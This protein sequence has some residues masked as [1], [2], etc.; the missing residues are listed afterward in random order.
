MTGCL[1]FPS[2]YN[3]LP[4][5]KSRSFRILVIC[6]LLSTAH[7]ITRSWVLPTH[8]AGQIWFH[9]KVIQ[10]FKKN[11]LWLSQSKKCFRPPLSW[12]A[13][14]ANQPAR[15][16]AAVE[17]SAPKCSCP[18]DL[19]SLLQAEDSSTRPP[20]RQSESQGTH[21][22]QNGPVSQGP[23]LCCSWPYRR[24]HLHYLRVAP[25]SISQETAELGLTKY[26]V[27]CGRDTR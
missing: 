16:H 5:G 12:K 8:Q 3:L 17:R 1:C 18:P 10:N 23:R 2:P 26:I 9:Y 6:C 25:Q 21:S 19:P 14:T 13:G 7:W 11:V 27:S 20:S 15:S 24:S 22:A 4:K